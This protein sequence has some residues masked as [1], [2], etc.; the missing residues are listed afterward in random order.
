MMSEL[1]EKEG[2]V[3]ALA[4]AYCEGQ[5]LRQI[6]AQPELHELHRHP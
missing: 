4:K 3:T 2:E 1:K 6:I 5:L